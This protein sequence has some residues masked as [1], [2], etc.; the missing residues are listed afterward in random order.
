M[1]VFGYLSPSSSTKGWPVDLIHQ[2][3]WAFVT[4]AVA[5]LIL[6]IAARRRAP[7]FVCNL[8]AIFG[9]A[10]AG[11]G[12]VMPFELAPFFFGLSQEAMIET[13][14]LILVYPIAIFAFFLL[15]RGIAVAKPPKSPRR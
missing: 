6:A 15:F 12:L 2:T 11:L 13:F 4:V 9:G 14:V 10:G 7:E 1:F 3:E 8:I 5:C